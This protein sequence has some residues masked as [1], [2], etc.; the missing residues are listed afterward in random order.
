MILIKLKKAFYF[1]SIN[2]NNPIKPL[3]SQFQLTSKSE[4]LSIE[5]AL[6]EPLQKIIENSG[7]QNAS[8]ENLYNS[9]K[10]LK[11]RNIN[12]LNTEDFTAIYK[13]FSTAITETSSSSY[14]SLEDTSIED[15]C[16][17]EQLQKD[18]LKF[19]QAIFRVSVEGMDDFVLNI[20]SS[21]SGNLSLELVQPLLDSNVTK[22]AANASPSDIEGVTFPELFAKDNFD[23]TF[24]DI[25]NEKGQA[26]LTKQDALN[27][28]KELVQLVDSCKDIRLE[29]KDLFRKV[30]LLC[31][32]QHIYSPF[33]SSSKMLLTILLDLLSKPD[34]AIETSGKVEFVAKD[35]GVHVKFSYQHQIVLEK[36]QK[37]YEIPLG[38]WNN[39]CEEHNIPN[40]IGL[41]GLGEFFVSIKQGEVEFKNIKHTARLHASIDPNS[42][43][44]KALNLDDVSKLTT[45]IE[46]LKSSVTHPSKKQIETLLSSLLPF[47]Q[48]MH[49]MN[50]AQYEIPESFENAYLAGGE[51]PPTTV[52]I[53]GARLVN[54]RDKDSA[55]QVIL[56]VEELAKSLTEDP[57]LQEAITLQILNLCSQKVLKSLNTAQKDLIATGFDLD[58]QSNTTIR[59]ERVKGFFGGIKD[60]AI[61]CKISTDLITY[62]KG[63]LTK[64]NSEE[65]NQ[66][67]SSLEMLGCAVSTTAESSFV[68][69][70][71]K[72]LLGGKISYE[73]KEILHKVT[74][75]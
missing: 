65:K 22:E 53:G 25:T 16:S 5:K 62:P 59:F 38:S 52:V 19:Q 17:V 9:L 54:I 55:E 12:A 49:P 75:K 33:S 32:T 39:F 11:E 18:F 40:K 26:L 64:L 1:M 45:T 2:P 30:L 48:T 14:T 56:N 31:R 27:L 41:G 13:A 61:R 15:L 58:F 72:N 74:S 42:I 69:E 6:L 44:S 73:L 68:L 23:R 67:R 60:D 34:Y 20:I 10:H 37:K 57:K 29:D 36:L 21:Q 3:F 46:P 70:I 24:S 51:I 47:E 28:N 63:D 71:N 7:K 66:Y 8:L 4:D 50:F 35:D 43:V